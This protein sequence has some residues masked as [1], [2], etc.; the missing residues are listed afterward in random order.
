MVTATTPNWSDYQQ[1]E[2]RPEQV[3]ELIRF[4]TDTVAAIPADR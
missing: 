2:V 4:L 1:V 3:E